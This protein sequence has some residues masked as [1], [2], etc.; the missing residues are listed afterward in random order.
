M[1]ETYEPSGEGWH[2]YEAIQPE[3]GEVVDFW[4]PSTG[5]KWFGKAEFAP[6]FNI[7]GLF[8]RPIERKESLIIKSDLRRGD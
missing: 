2:R 1:S 4:R 6:E 8:W 5:Q 7:A 3:A